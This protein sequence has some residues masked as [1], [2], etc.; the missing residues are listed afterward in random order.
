VRVRIRSIK[1][2]RLSDPARLPARERVHG[3]PWL[4]AADRMVPRLVGPARQRHKARRGYSRRSSSDDAPT[5]WPGKPPALPRFKIQEERKADEVCALHRFALAWTAASLWIGP[6]DATA[7][8]CAARRR[9]GLAGGRRKV[10]SRAG[11]AC[12]RLIL[13]APGASNGEVHIAVFFNKDLEI[14][15]A[16]GDLHGGP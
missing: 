8:A 15:S 16:V 7:G 2:A 12:V 3:S 13:L 4:C 6:I 14:Y 1:A 10:L 5:P 9:R 11:R